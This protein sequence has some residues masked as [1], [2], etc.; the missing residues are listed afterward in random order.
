VALW[1]PVFWNAKWSVAETARHRSLSTRHH[2]A[3]RP[4][5]RGP[6][7]SPAL[8]AVAA[9]VKGMPFWCSVVQGDFTHVGTTSLFRRLMT[10]ETEF[11]RLYAISQR[12]ATTRQPGLKS[13]GVVVDSV[14]SG[15]GNWDRV[16]IVIECNLDRGLYAAS[17]TVLHG[18]E[19]ITSRWK[20][21]RIPS[22]INCPWPYRTAAVV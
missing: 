17:G 22:C 1:D 19:G 2:G 12:V 9:A 6:D 10:E 8:H 11:S 20:F 3:N 21:P 5:D 15:A 7:D 18:L 14:I 4:M 13:A 16:A